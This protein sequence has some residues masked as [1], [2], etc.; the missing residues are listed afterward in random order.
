MK[1]G[2]QLYL[3]CTR[4]LY[5]TLLIKYFEYGGKNMSFLIKND[6]VLEIY[7]QI[8]D[9]IKSKLGIKFHCLSVYDKNT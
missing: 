6:E 2:E 3:E 8:W 5:F 7:E 1:R 4:S 9:L